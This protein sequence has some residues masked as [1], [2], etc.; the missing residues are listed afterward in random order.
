[1]GEIAAVA[2]A[3]TDWAGR[4]GRR[5]D[6]ANAA[7]GRLVRLMDAWFAT[8]RQD[9]RFDRFGVHFDFLEPALAGATER[10]RAEIGEPD[11][12]RPGTVYDRCRAVEQGLAV[13]HRLFAWYAE[14]YD[15]RCN[16]RLTSVLGAAD[17]LV[18]SCWVEPFRRAGVPCPTGPL[19]FVAPQWGAC[20]TVR[21]AVPRPL[22]RDAPDLVGDLVR[23]L[24]IPVISLPETVTGQGWWL[25][26]A[27]HEVGHHVAGDL[28]RDGDESLEDRAAD[29]L[30]DALGHHDPARGALWPTWA[31]ELFADAFAAVAV[32]EAGAWATHE[33][34]YT[35]PTAFFA[36][37]DGGAYPPP[38]IRLAVAGET[39]RRLGTGTWPPGAEDV[40]Q[41]LRYAALPGIAEDDVAA[42]LTLAAPAAEALLDLPVGGRRLADLFDN[43]AGWFAPRGRVADWTVELR[44][45]DPHLHP[46]G[47]AEAARLTV[48][49][50]VRAYRAGASDGLH[51]RLVAAMAKAGPPGTLAPGGAVGMHP[52]DA[53]GLIVRALKEAR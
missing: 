28:G 22:R 43:R 36:T 19:T 34:E 10:L 40:R 12:D 29:A 49:A 46:I 24:P 31:A 23:T 7:A 47:G 9:R 32:A 20:A 2:A 14:K 17:E 6:E 11:D 3:G 48:L 35:A 37:P 21:D 41:W 16:D 51:E 33:L 50:G 52:A 5:A 27:A 45:P 18:R 13:V 42:H 30:A 25:A 53:A 44:G 26:L 15:Q 38:A 8:R 39:V 4:T 1:M